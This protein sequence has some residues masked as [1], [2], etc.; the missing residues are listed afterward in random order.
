MILIRD[1]AGTHSINARQVGFI[2][3]K[4][5]SLYKVKN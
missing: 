4:C 3:K 1:T 2:N 5:I